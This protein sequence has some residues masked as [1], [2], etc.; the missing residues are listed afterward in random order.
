[1]KGPFGWY[2]P[3]CCYVSNHTIRIGSLLFSLFQIQTHFMKI[4]ET[5]PDALVAACSIFIQ[6][7]A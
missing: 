2:R 3:P 5:A 6:L 4:Q 7:A 1:M